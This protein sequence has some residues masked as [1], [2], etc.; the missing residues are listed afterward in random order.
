MAWCMRVDNRDEIR[1]YIICG[2][3]GAEKEVV[4]GLQ[5]IKHRSI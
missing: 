4:V 3:V 5:D 2:Q 1:D